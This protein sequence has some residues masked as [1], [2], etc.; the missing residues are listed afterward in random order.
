MSQ[1]K[2]V[3]GNPI[4]IDELSD[5]EKKQAIHEWS[6]GNPELEKLL[7][8][9]DKN[10]IEIYEFCTDYE[11]IS[12]NA[13]I[14]M[15][16]EFGN[17]DK[18]LNL[19]ARMNENMLFQLRIINDKDV[20]C[21]AT[22]YSAEKKYNEDFFKQINQKFDEIDRGERTSKYVLEKYKAL[23]G[24][25]EKEADY[26]RRTV[27]IY[28]DDTLG[29]RVA[30]WDENSAI[31]MQYISEET[32]KIYNERLDNYVRAKEE[33]PECIIEEP[34]STI[35]TINQEINEIKKK[36]RRSRTPISAIK[37]AFLNIKEELF[38]GKTQLKGEMVNGSR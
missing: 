30:L 25:A 33:D 1:S 10:G 12:N 36:A 26:N 9:C 29:I 38:S 27:E 7:K 14:S 13:Y 19:L 34:Y 8:Y 21:H 37:K 3:N 11:D 35:E 4:Q 28:Q 18:V 31:F 2:Y 15:V 5:E 23:K 32:A 6:G 16:L 20:P 17:S 22:I 24:I